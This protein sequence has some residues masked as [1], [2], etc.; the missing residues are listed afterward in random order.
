LAWVAGGRDPFVDARALEA[1]AGGFWGGGAQVVPTASHMDVGADGVVAALRG[2][3]Q[4]VA[5]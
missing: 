4:A 2:F 5:R 3:L 1:I